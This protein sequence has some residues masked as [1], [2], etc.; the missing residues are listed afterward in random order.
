MAA[1]LAFPAAA[2]PRGR[3][4]PHAG[5]VPAEMA[6]ARLLIEAARFRDAQA[7][8]EQARFTD[9]EEETGRRFLLGMVHMRLDMPRRAAEQYE[10]ILARRPGLTRVRLEL[11]SA[12]FAAGL[13]GRARRHFELALGDGL[14]PSARR[15]VERTLALIETRKRWSANVSTML[16]PETN[17][18]RNTEARTVRIGGAE[19]R[20]AEDARPRPGVG[21]ELLSDAA[22]T[23]HLAEDLRGHV[24]LSARTRLHRRSEWNDTAV[25]AEVGT[26][27]SFDLSSISGGVRGGRRWIG[28][29]PYRRTIGPW[30][31][32]ERR[33]SVRDRIG[34]DARLERRRHDE[35]RSRDGWRA[36]LAASFRHVASSRAEL[37]A[38]LSVEAV[39]AR[40]SHEASRSAGLEAGL[41]RAFDG[42]VVVSLD[43]SLRQGQYRAPHPLFRA[44]RRDRSLRLEVRALHR[45]LRV[46]GF[47]PWIGY[48]HERSLSTIPLYSYRNHGLLLGVSRSF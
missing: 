43:A 44:R 5:A 40:E 13:D 32:A 34:L 9:A 39:T 11:A 33:L 41:S 29:R 3:E 47:S 27:R 25:F 22:W 7:L 4:A 12:Y 46:R 20:L 10:A 35:A 1:S 2:E 19:F 23:P 6:L 37:R 21:A 42:G 17:A 31:R 14:P 26:K 45:A 38:G 24:A 48:V 36:V 28:E 18:G 30:V 16:V 8:L 15:V